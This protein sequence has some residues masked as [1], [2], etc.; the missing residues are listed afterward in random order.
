MITL[1]SGLGPSI[2]FWVCQT[3]NLEMLGVGCTTI[4][5]Y[6]KETNR[7]LTWS[8]LEYV[9]IIPRFPANLL[10]NKTVDQLFGTSQICLRYD[11]F[12]K[13]H[14]TTRKLYNGTPRTQQ[15]Y[16]ISMSPHPIPFHYI[17]N[18][19]ILNQTKSNELESRW[20]RG[21]N[22]T[23]WSRIFVPSGLQVL[24]RLGWTKF[25]YYQF[26]QL[27]PGHVDGIPVRY[28]RGLDR[29]PI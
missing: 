25:W 3:K 1:R 12:R 7:W 23:L 18:A 16:L 13:W 6:K 27:W 10:V 14:S 28:P 19:W 4:K 11:I 15:Q 24:W 8:R 21:W 29:C 26:R 22:S 20:I 9:K 2:N 17:T 5:L